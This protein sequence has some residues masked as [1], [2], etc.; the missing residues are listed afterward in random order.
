MTMRLDRLQAIRDA[1][2]KA[3]PDGFDLGE[4]S[5]C[6]W[7]RAYK[8]GAVPRASSQ[9]STMADFLG[10]SLADARQVFGGE[11]SLKRRY[12]FPAAMADLD[13]LIEKGRAEQREATMAKLRTMADDPHHV[14][15][16]KTESLGTKIA[17]KLIAEF[18]D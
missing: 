16:E 8:S 3:G 5:Y 18:L 17:R 11:C 12:D 1:N 7:G 4:W 15:I 14:A 13:A 10:V 2:A 6:L 9:W